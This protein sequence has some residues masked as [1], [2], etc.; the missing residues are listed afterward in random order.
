M[1]ICL[2]QSRKNSLQA[3]KLFL[4]AGCNGDH[5][6]AD[7]NTGLVFN[8]T[9]MTSVSSSNDHSRVTFAT[10]QRFFSITKQGPLDPWCRVLSI[11]LYRPGLI[12]TCPTKL[13]P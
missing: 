7:T 4:V 11:A 1:Y 12:A 2:Q 13:P 8:P 5:M 3:N 6:Y 10:R 9:L